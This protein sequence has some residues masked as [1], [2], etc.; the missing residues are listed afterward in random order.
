MAQAFG[1]HS[2]SLLPGHYGGHYH[3][4]LL[5]RNSASPQ[6]QNNG[7]RQLELK[8]LKLRPKVNIFLLQVTFSGM[9]LKSLLI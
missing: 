4:F 3:I 9:I 2:I 6:A 8:L 7:S 1:S 5:S